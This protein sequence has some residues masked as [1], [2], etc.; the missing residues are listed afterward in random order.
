MEPILLSL[1]LLAFTACNEAASYSASTPAQVLRAPAPSSEPPP[2]EPQA[3]ISIIN[4]DI[5]E[6][7]DFPS[8]CSFIASDGGRCSCVLLGPQVMLTA[9]H[10]VARRPRENTGRGNIRVFNQPGM[11]PVECL[12]AGGIDLAICE[13]TDRVDDIRFERLNREPLNASGN[14]LL[15]TGFGCT[16]PG[17]G[18]GQL[19]KLATTFTPFLGPPP[20]AIPIGE[21]AQLCGG[22]SGGPAYLL[23]SNDHNGPRR[24]AGINFRNFD[25]TNVSTPAATDFIRGWARDHPGLAICGLN[26]N[27]ARTCRR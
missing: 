7:A 6:W 23:L 13:V 21:G 17:I 9:E 2:S 22:D 20:E 5:A 11:R 18:A 4:G 19:R 16:A 8:T 12:V 3:E 26:T 27:N 24:V 10:C 15:L 14:P 25:V 1:A